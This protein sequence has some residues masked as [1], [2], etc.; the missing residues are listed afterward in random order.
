MP[1][2][3]VVQ[4]A[5][6]SPSV[7]P[8][9]STTARSIITVRSFGHW[10]PMLWARHSSRCLPKRPQLLTSSRRARSSTLHPH[11]VSVRVRAKVLWSSP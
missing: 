8:D 2:L 7:R 5:Y 10:Q 9:E 11:Y 4:S 3:E 1:P 6:I